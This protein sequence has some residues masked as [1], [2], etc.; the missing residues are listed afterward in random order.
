MQ[1]VGRFVPQKD[2]PRCAEYVRRTMPDPRAV[3]VNRAIFLDRDGTLIEDSG[4]L[5]RPDD[6]VVLPNVVEALALLRRAGFRLIVVTNQSGVARGLYTEDDIDAVHAELVRRLGAFDAL[7]HCPHHEAGTEA[8]YAIACRC[9]KPGPEMVERGIAAFDLDPA[10]CHIV[11]DRDSDL[12]A[13]AAV[14]VRGWKVRSGPSGEGDWDD[15]LAVA[16]EVTR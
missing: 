16:R 1:S 14:G 7:Y 13:G 6:M 10:A 9:R 5:F 12:E 3:S 8:P 4:Y 2:K 11:G 15:L